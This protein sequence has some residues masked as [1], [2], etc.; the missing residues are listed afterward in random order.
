MAYIF[1]VIMEGGVM[2]VAV[3]MCM[4]WV[5]RAICYIWRQRSGKWQE[6]QVI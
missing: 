5:I 1:G 2:G 6:F 3:A 4:D